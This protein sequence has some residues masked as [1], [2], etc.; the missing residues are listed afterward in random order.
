[1]YRWIYSQGGYPKGDDIMVEKARQDFELAQKENQSY[2][3]DLVM[4]S[5]SQAKEGKTKD[6]NQVCERLENKYTGA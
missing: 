4:Q 5:I 1:M 6:F 3:R 2:I